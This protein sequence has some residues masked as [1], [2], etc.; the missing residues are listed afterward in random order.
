MSVDNVRKLDVN[1]KNI[2]KIWLLIALRFSYTQVILINIMQ[3]SNIYMGTFDFISLHL[4]MDLSG[5]IP[6]LSMTEHQKVISGLIRKMEK[7]YWLMRHHIT[8]KVIFGLGIMM[9][10][11][12][13]RMEII[14]LRLICLE[15][16]VCTM[17]VL[18]VLKV[19][20]LERKGFKRIA[21]LYL[22]FIL[23]IWVLEGIFKQ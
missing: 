21:R 9:D 19:S 17:K 10:S 2:L 6:Y 7:L 16:S 14:R 18:P 15:R 4:K 8:A 11:Q 3:L 13:W 1:F 22:G 12:S 5:V 23:T 20:G